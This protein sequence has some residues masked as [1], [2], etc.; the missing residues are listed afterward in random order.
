MPSATVAIVPLD[1]RAVNYECLV[2]LGEAAGLHVLMPPKSWLGTSWRAGAVDELGAW[3]VDAA[4]QADAVI[5]AVD[6]LGYGGLVD[7]RRSSETLGTVMQRL[8]VL[9]SIKAARPETTVLAF[10]VLMRITR[11]NDAEEEKPYWAT[12]GA[13]MF[14]L[15]YL[16]D[17]AAMAVGTADEAEEIAALRREVPADLLADYQAGRARNH[18]VNR[19]MIEWAAGGIFDY[20]IVPQDDTVDYGWNIAE[21]RQLRQYVRELGVTQRVAIYPGTDETAMLLLARF[22]AQRA[23]F[24]PR[25]WLRYS[26]SGAEQII[27]AYED[28]PMTEM[29]KAHLGPLNGIVCSD[30]TAADL[31]LYINAP[32]EIQ[33]N[34]PEQYLLAL[35]KQAMDGLP[36][37]IQ[38]MV[39]AYRRQPHVAATLREMHSVRRDLPEFVRSLARDLEHGATCAVVD[40]AFVNAGDLVLGELLTQLP[41]LSQLAAF[42]GWNTAGNTLGS[43]LAH[44]VIRHVQRIQG[45]TAGALAAHVRYLFLRLVEDYLYMSRVRTAL[46]VEDL[47]NLGLPPIL[48]NL[49]Q[50]APAVRSIVEQKLGAAAAL[51]A[52]S[53]FA[54]QTIAA[55]E[56]HLTIESLSLE[57]ICLPWDR[58]FDLTAGVSIRYAAH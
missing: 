1:D 3:L 25:V 31:R 57:D 54:G 53:C 12:F 18:A 4:Q 40:V 14:R 48:T 43:V 55:G 20:L 23:G 32:A 56:L 34:G 19:A 45:A 37:S 33:G 29:V 10:N 16:E 47:P 44:A 13:R 41:N 11:S 28:R 9:R 39:A 58:L 22:V 51:L 17:R 8:E 5:V 49:G 24:A 2:M 21:A 15:S 52:E 30:P 35:P 27:T 36:A 46:M 42:G 6:T 7:S 50:H 38:Q 26:G